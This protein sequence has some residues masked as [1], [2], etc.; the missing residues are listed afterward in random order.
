MK[1][2]FLGAFTFQT[3]A[4]MS[5]WLDDGHEI[6]GF[7]YPHTFSRRD[8]RALRVLAR[9]WSVSA[10]LAQHRITA[11]AVQR[12]SQWDG[13]AEAAIATGADVVISAY[14]TYIVPPAVLACFPGR[15]VNIH[16]ALLPR[17]RGPDPELAMI[18]D[19][20]IGN[21]AGVTVHVMSEGIDEGDIIAQQ[22]VDFP[23]DADTMRHLICIGQAITGM[24]QRVPVYMRR[25]IVPAVQ[26]ETN[27]SY[28]RVDLDRDLVIGFGHSAEEADWLCRTVPQIWPLRVA[29]AGSLGV[30]PPVR[31]IGP[32]TGKAPIVR[33]FSIECDVSDGRILLRRETFLWRTLQR[34]RFGVLLRRTPLYDTG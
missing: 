19:R 11:T 22:P 28:R 26:D 24:V 33:P 10:L 23:V 16:P 27:A 5:A 25:E 31:V 32:P 4:A 18:I 34:W 17:Y 7:W 13:A 14:F 1:A 12:L 2:L 21:A 29:G 9:Q 30:R 20:T 3:A 6:V 8:D 15:I